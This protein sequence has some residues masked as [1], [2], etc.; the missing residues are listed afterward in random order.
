MPKAHRLK[1]WPEPFQAVIDGQKRFEFR[2][3]DRGFA[4]G[5]TL[6]L[7]EWD[8]KTERLTGRCATALV[9]Y[10]VAGPR[11]GIPK[12]YVVMSLGEPVRS[13]SS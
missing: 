8:Q 10:I 9:T 7:D 12:G 11:F 5:D 4:L 1:T 2:K 13:S 6:V 3:D